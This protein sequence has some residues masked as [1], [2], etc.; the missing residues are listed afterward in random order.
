MSIGRSKI[1]E[2]RLPYLVNVTHFRGRGNVYIQRNAKGVGMIGATV[3]KIMEVRLP[4][5]IAI[6]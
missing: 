6:L 2:V 1:M 4:Y 3:V 5:H